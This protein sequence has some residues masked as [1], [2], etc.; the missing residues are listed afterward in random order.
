[1]TSPNGADEIARRATQPAEG[2]RGRA[3]HGRDA[4]RARDRARVR[5]RASR[6]ATGCSPSSAPGRARPL[7]ARPRT[8]GAARSTRSEPTSSPLYARCSLQPD[9]AR[10]RRR[11]ARVRLG[12]PRVRLDRRRGAGGLDRPRDDAASRASVG[13]DGRARGRDRTIST[14]SSPPSPSTRPRWMSYDTITFLT[15]FGLQDDFVGV[16]HGVIKRRSPATRRSSTSRTASAPQAVTEGALVLARARRPTCRSAVHLA[17]VDPGRRRRSPRGRDPDAGGGIFVGPDNG[18]LS[19]AAP[20]GGVAAV[21]CADQPALPPRARLAHLPCARHLRSGRRAPCGRRRLR[22][23]RRGGR[24]R[25]ARALELPQPERRPVGAAGD[26]ARGRSLRQ[27]RAE[28][29][30]GRRRRGRPAPGDRGRAARSR[31]NPLLRGRRRDAMPTPA[32]RADPL[33]GL[34]RRLLDR[35]QRRQRRALTDGGVGRGS[36]DSSREGTDS[37]QRV[38]RAGLEPATPRFSAVCSTS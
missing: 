15:D 35:D 29:D 16:C 23:S 24:S 11:R 12:R 28:R 6:R 2:R 4:A 30:A 14:G 26:G 8:R 22:R 5:R 19:L 7:P 38:A 20:A 3:G 36:A 18:L 32:R 34:L 25:D 31:L 27:P 10:G 17:V 37:E 33:R 13:L 1:M 21:R 9:A